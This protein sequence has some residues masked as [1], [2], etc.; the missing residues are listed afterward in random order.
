VL[1]KGLTRT[2]QREAKV[3]A[4]DNGDGHI[5]EPVEDVRG[6]VHHGVQ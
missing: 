6:A 5:K 4:L 1:Q 2:D 3:V